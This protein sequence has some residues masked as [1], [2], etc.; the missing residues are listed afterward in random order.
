[1][2]RAVPWWRSSAA[3]SSVVAAAVAAVLVAVLGA[4]PPT[5]SQTALYLGRFHVLVVHLPIGF[6]VLLAFADA[7]TLLGRWRDRL[8]PA[9]G[10]LLPPALAA[11]LA[12]LALGLLAASGGGYPSQL[13]ALHRGFALAATIG[14]AACLVAWAA[15]RARGGRLTRAATH[16]TMGVTLGLIGVTGHLGGS[17]THGEGFLTRGAPASVSRWVGAAPEPER[18]PSRPAAQE[19]AEP[20]VFDHVVAPL[21]QSRCSRCHGRDR[22]SGGLR[23]D[24]L[25]GLRQGGGGPVVVPGSAA[26]SELVFRVELPIDDSRHMPPRGQPGLAPEEI[27]LLRWWIDRGA[28]ESPRVGDVLAPDGVR[29]L[30]AGAAARGERPE[31]PAV[32]D[33]APAADAGPAPREAPVELPRP[34]EGP[35][36]RTPRAS[37]APAARTAAPDAAAAPA[38][39]GAALVRERCVQC[40]GLDR[41]TSERRTAQEWRSV[42][43]RM[44]ALGARLAPDERQAVL[45]YLIGRFSAPAGPSQAPPG[46]QPAARPRAGDE[47]ERERERDEADDE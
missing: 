14:T 34:E 18:S 15:H 20:T 24:S 12:A 16:A 47:V 19:P 8:E 25:A 10:V 45:S 40:H 35:A 27:E 7:L 6:I 30:I 3:L 32:P 4:A 1:M 37:R 29:R 17:L 42:V 38:L 39:S 11:A 22:A 43:A 2:A 21:L 36:R 23:L 44:E 41:V 26:R 31:A 9:V 13:V 5:D 33:A 46:A 28:G